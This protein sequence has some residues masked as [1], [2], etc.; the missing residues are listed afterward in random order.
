MRFREEVMEKQP[1]LGPGE[2]EEVM[3]EVL[4]TMRSGKE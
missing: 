3:K 2:G 1:F 4:G